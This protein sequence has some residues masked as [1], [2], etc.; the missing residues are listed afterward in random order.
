MANFGDSI[1]EFEIMLIAAILR[2]IIGQL[3]KR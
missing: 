3:I 1:A 2:A